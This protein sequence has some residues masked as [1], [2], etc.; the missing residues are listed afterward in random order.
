ME[1]VPQTDMVS[2]KINSAGLFLALQCPFFL[3]RHGIKRWYFPQGIT[4]E[5]KFARPFDIYAEMLTPPRTSRFN[6]SSLRAE[7]DMQSRTLACKVEQHSVNFYIWWQE[8]SC[9][10]IISLYAGISSELYAIA[11]VKCECL[12]SNQR[13]LC[14]FNVCSSEMRS[15]RIYNIIDIKKF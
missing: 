12:L 1:I 5:N 10:E 14:P 2:L 13:I 9:C 3:F 6:S 11:N 7:V 15:N 4:C 8:R